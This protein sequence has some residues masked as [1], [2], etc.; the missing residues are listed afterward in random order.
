MTFA[1]LFSKERISPQTSSNQAA[2]SNQQNANKTY[3]AYWE[4]VNCLQKN[5]QFNDSAILIE[6][7]SPQCKRYKAAADDLQQGQLQLQA[8]TKS[9]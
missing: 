7:C 4:L 6:S 8:P 5:A 2:S 1:R 3:N 9:R